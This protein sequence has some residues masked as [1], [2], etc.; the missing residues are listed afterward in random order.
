MTIGTF[1]DLAASSTT[2][3]TS[4]EV[5]GTGGGGGG[6]EGAVLVLPHEIERVASNKRDKT[7]QAASAD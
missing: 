2:C 3:C 5:S 4:A 1:R 7:A 6:G